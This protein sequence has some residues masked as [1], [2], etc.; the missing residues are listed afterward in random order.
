MA[1]KELWR[2]RIQKKQRDR[3]EKNLPKFFADFSERQIKLNED[4]L[5]ILSENYL[6][7]FPEVGRSKS[8]QLSVASLHAYWFCY[9]IMR[10]G[11]MNKTKDHELS[12]EQ[13]KY[14][15]LD[16]MSMVMDQ[17]LN[18]EKEFA[19]NGIK[20]FKEMLNKSVLKKKLE[21]EQRETMKEIDE[22]M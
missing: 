2:K 10:L 13:V 8:H 7:E 17:A 4:F 1:D 18:R 5:N 15:G 3:T 12:M 16:L 9:Y 11:T 19:E 6:D 22:L 20:I 14:L 21:K